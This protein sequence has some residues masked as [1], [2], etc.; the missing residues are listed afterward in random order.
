MLE[1]RVNPPSSAVP[2][3]ASGTFLCTS[4][5]P[6]YSATLT[7]SAHG[8]GIDP[9]CP[10]PPTD[11]RLLRPGAWL[12]G[13]RP[14]TLC[15]FWAPTAS[16]LLC[17]A[18]YL[19]GP[20]RSLL[21]LFWAPTASRPHAKQSC[22]MGPAFPYYICQTKPASATQLIHA[23]QCLHHGCVGYERYFHYPAETLKICHPSNFRTSVAHQTSSPSS[24]N[25]LNGCYVSGGNEQ[26]EQNDSRAAVSSRRCK[27]GSVQPRDRDWWNSSC[28]E[29]SW[30]EIWPPM[31]S[32]VV[33]NLIKG[34][35]IATNDKIAIRR[36]A[37]Q[38]TRA[39]AALKS[40][41]CVT[42]INQ[43]N[44][45]SMTERLPKH[46]QDKFATLAYNLEAKG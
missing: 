21:H 33:N 4:T 3:T 14:S 8:S 43:G 5:L 45:A 24:S 38:A 18:T 37:D 15:L 1:R 28:T 31:C 39:L 41:N 32:S 44:I 22:S 10:R 11:S 23:R 34:P 27:G 9:H 42:E 16:C 13:P 7:T 2:S 35:S 40:M 29:G 30:G 36:F 26:R 17:K 12:H 20:R 6:L 46:L 25:D 19:H